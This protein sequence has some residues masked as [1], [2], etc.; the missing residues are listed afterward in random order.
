MKGKI[1]LICNNTKCKK[2][3]EATQTEVDRGRKFCSLQCSVITKRAE[4]KS[5][6]MNKEYDSKGEKNEAYT[7]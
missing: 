1:K 2:E 6:K 4:R 3:F 5:Q 7:Y